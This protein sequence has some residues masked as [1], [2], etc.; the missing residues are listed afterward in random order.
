MELSNIVESQKAPPPP[1]RYCLTP[2]VTSEIGNVKCQIPNTIY[3]SPSHQRPLDPHKNWWELFI[4]GQ[5]PLW[6]MSDCRQ[7]ASV[8]HPHLVKREYCTE[9]QQRVLEWCNIVC[10][11]HF[12]LL[13][14]TQ[15][16][17]KE[18]FYLSG[19]C[20]CEWYWCWCWWSVCVWVE[21]GLEGSI[22][23]G[24]Y[25]FLHIYLIT[26]NIMNSYNIF[27]LWFS[28]PNL[29]WYKD[30]NTWGVGGTGGIIFCWLFS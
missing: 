2:S 4:I 14:R 29:Y 18:S 16:S 3:S 23:C 10:A 11:A 21:G 27:R 9:P 15:Y 22:V 12:A 8:S 24:Y 25:D 28:A 1:P 7:P 6:K 5:L 17:L 20:T 19:V 30:S 26:P 13:Q